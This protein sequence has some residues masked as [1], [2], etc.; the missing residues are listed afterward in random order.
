MHSTSLDSPRNKLSMGGV[1]GVP[2]LSMLQTN[3][4][5]H[6]LLYDNFV[7]VQFVTTSDLRM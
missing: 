3:A 1:S 5:Q 7:T 4:V 2:A 6:R